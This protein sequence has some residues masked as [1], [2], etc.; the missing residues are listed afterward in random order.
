M[1]TDSIGNVSWAKRESSITE[2][3]A[4]TPTMVLT[5]DSAIVVAYLSDSPLLSGSDVSF[6]KITLTGTLLWHRIQ[7][8]QGGEIVY[9]LVNLYDNGFMM[10]TGNLFRRFDSFGNV[11]SAIG[12]NPGFPTSFSCMI[13]TKNDNFII[14]GIVNQNKAEM[15][16]SIND[17]IGLSACP[18]INFTNLYSIPSGLTLTDWQINDSDV[19]FIESAVSITT[20]DSIPNF[21]YVCFTA[22]DE[23]IGDVVLTVYP[24]P[25]VELIHIEAKVNIEQ[26]EI[27]S[28]QGCIINKK[29]CERRHESINVKNLVTGIYI[30]KIYTA[31][32]IVFKKIVKI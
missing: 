29:L 3:S 9:D 19:T 27:Y 8:D 15:L 31:K 11:L 6:A 1:R 14:A 20:Y 24:N 17:S 13:Q 2:Q 10:M 16:V 18:N 26:I 32:E 22:V 5:K 4:Y 28:L 25:T 30:L 23:I 21:Q 7:G 12:Q